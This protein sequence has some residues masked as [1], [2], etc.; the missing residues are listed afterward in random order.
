MDGERGDDDVE[1]SS[2]YFIFYYSYMVFKIVGEER[3]YSTGRGRV[4]GAVP[5]LRQRI[6]KTTF[7]FLLHERMNFIL[8]LLIY[9]F[10]LGI[11]V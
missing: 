3:F 11:P 4:E 7:C 6:I 9:L 2:L 8:N 10:I 1:A 5:S